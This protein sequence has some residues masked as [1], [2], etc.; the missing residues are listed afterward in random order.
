MSIIS[1]ITAKFYDKIMQD[2]EMRG[3][4]NWRAEL[5][6]NATGVTLEIGAGTGSNL[7]Y[8]PDTISKLILLEP[9][10]HMRRQLSLKLPANSPYSIELLTG[11]AESILLPDAIFN[12]VICALVLCSV[13]NIEKTLSE[14]HRVLVPGGK[15]IFIEHIAATNNSHRLKW[16]RRIEPL[17]KVIASGCHLTRSTEEQL[18]QAG[19]VIKDITRESMRGVPPIVRPS[20]RGVAVKQ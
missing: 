18:I 12:T 14:L 19:F 6:S 2:A 17:W 10:P 3:L 9:D 4:Q 11:K 15:L 5:L 8:Y 13:K 20:I 16:Q 7:Q 1:R